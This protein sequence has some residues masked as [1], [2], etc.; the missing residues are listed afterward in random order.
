MDFVE[1]AMPIE[2]EVIL[3]KTGPSAFFGTPLTAQLAALG[4]D[5][6]V[7]CGE[8]TSGCIR[9][10]VV[11]GCSLGFRMIVA[12]EAVYD[13]HEASHAINL[14]DMAQKYADVLPVADVVA[15]ISA[16]ASGLARAEP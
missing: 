2:G 1:Q 10:T 5:T 6:L 15:G 12:Q 3:K 8:T 16:Y 14:F 13:R 4:V 9:A 7:V 11:D